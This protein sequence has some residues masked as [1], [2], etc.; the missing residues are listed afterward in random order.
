MEPSWS[1]I[2]PGETVT[3][4]CTISGG[5]NNEWIYEW[6]K[7]IFDTLHT[8]EYRIAHASE[9]SSGIYRCLGKQKEDPY[10][11]TEWSDITTVTVSGEDKHKLEPECM[12]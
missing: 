9:S 10:S 6:S 2:Y 7:P 12:F 3:I 5:E 4:R 11:S 8:N 1:L